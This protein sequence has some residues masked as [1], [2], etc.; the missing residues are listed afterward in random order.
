MNQTRTDWLKWVAAA[1]ALTATVHAEY[2]LARAIG[3]H[4]WV[5]LAVPG[6]LDAYVVRAL[7]AHREVFTAV[8]VL[9]FVNAASHLVSAG[10]LPA[11][12]WVTITAVSAIAPLVLWRVHALSTPGEVRRKVIWNVPADAPVPV[13]VPETVPVENTG[14]V[15]SEW[16]R[17][18]DRH[19]ED[20]LSV[21]VPD[22]VPEE[23]KRNTTHTF[24]LVGR[25][26]A[27]CSA[28]S[29][30]VT[31]DDKTGWTHD[32]PG[33]ACPLNEQ[34]P[35]WGTRLSLVPPLPDG[36]VPL[37]EQDENAVSEDVLAVLQPGDMSFLALARMADRKNRY[38]NDRPAT[39]RVLKDVCRVGTE[40]A[41]RLAAAVLAEHTA[42]ERTGNT[43]TDGGNDSA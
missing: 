31:Y 43:S 9:V 1:F 28:C 22:Y 13:A 42:R 23:L 12:N 36:F 11:L 30:P 14:P 27:D 15:T 38:E 41:Q 37:G 29:G 25:E 10:L 34:H 2:A 8:V 33:T 39:V 5:A 35:A 6:A 7:R 24:P 40:R 18:W 20:A 4:E 32:D 19:T 26:H 16:D 21:A 3:M 17:S